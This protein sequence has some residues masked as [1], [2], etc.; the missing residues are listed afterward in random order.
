[1][2]YSA[3][4]MRRAVFFSALVMVGGCVHARDFRAPD[5]RIT[6][7]TAYTLQK[8]EGRAEVDLVGFGV[9]DLGLN[10]GVYGGVT[11]RFQLGANLAHAGFGL[12]NAGAKV[13]IVDH[14]VVGVGVSTGII[15][16][17]PKVIWALPSALREELGRVNVLIIPSELTTTFPLTEWMGLHLTLGYKHVDMFG[18]FDSS[19]VL[20]KGGFGA[21]DLYLQ[22]TVDFYLGHRVAL[23]FN[24]H[25]S[26]WAAAR[27]NVA[28]E[29][30]IKPGVVAGVIGEEW[31]R[32]SFDATSNYSTAL[33]V[34]F[35]RNTYLQLAVVFGRFK[36][37][38][39]LPVL[40]A[41]RLYW[42]FAGPSA[43]K[44]RSQHHED[45]TR[46]RAK[47]AQKK[48]RKAGAS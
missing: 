26:A 45:K 38:P 7:G 41:M 9:Q 27:A 44:R 21:R 35:A 28:V 18:A 3:G 30:E 14:P 4:S 8:H 24:A 12:L 10:V 39:G 1:V 36:P 6:D 22:P 31:R 19:S 37:L 25:L 32:L 11:K 13:N 20:A 5:E 42:K 2:R 46:R 15:Y 48:A 33:E 23:R 17:N 40:P 47:R 34:R 16:T 29:S 43:E